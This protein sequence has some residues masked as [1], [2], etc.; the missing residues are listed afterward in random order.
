MY[1]SGLKSVYF[2]IR[3]VKQ[4]FKMITYGAFEG[5]KLQLGTVI[6]FFRS[7][8]C[9]TTTTDNS[10]P[11]CFCYGGN[12]LAHLFMVLPRL[13]LANFTTKKILIYTNC[14]NISYHLIFYY[15]YS[16][17][18]CWDLCYQPLGAQHQ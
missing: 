8:H 4:I 13:Y 15:N 16:N 9:S 7:S 2:K 18:C 11:S 12:G 17:Y 1:V 14:N 5:K 3:G 6:F 10:E